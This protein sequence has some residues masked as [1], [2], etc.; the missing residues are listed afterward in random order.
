MLLY[1]SK[2][3][4]QEV[5]AQSS[6]LSVNDRRLHFGLGSEASASLEIVWPSR[7]TQKFSRVPADRL[8]TIDE[9]REIIAATPMGK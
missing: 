3:Q 4:L 9:E 5:C 6:F 2:K 7:I 1:G 8:V